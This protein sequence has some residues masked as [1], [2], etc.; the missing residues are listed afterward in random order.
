MSDDLQPEGP[1]GRSLTRLAEL[2]GLLRASPPTPPPGLGDQIVRSARYE[3]G[4]RA[5][6]RTAADLGTA[7]LDGLA[8]LL[9]LRRA[10]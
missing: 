9:G 8:V 1:A 6:A 4:I 2:L 5:S 3:R 7:V 10:R